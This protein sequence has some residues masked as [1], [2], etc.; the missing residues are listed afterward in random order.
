MFEAYFEPVS[1]QILLEDGVELPSDSLGRR[2]R[3][4]TEGQPFPEL[5]GVRI[6]IIGV[7]DE[8]GLNGEKGQGGGM[9]A[10][11]E[12]LYRLKAH[13]NELVIADFGNLRPGYS[14]E[15]TYAAIASVVSELVP[16]KIIPIFLGGSQDLTY[17][18]Y[19]G[20][21]KN[22]QIINIVS[23]D[24]RFDLGK[25]EDPLSAGS[26]L[27]KIVLEQPNYLFNFSNIGYQTY[28]VGNESVELMKKLFFDTY[29]LGQIRTDITEAEP[30]VRN[31]DVVTVDIS[32]IRQ[33]DAPGTRMA[34]P[35]GFY[36]EEICQIMM[37]TGMSE[38]LS[39]LG[40]YEYVEHLDR[41][42]QT[43]HLIAQMMWYF[44][45][46]VAN[47]KMDLPLTNPANY[48][49]YRVTVPGLTEE[50]TFIKS[51][52]TD[53]WWMKLPLDSSRNR[54]AGHHL[55]PCSYRDYQQACNSEVPDR[56]WNALQKML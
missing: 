25:P 37:Y 29:R 41:D 51:L 49:T 12:K 31:A 28:F 53:R 27:G 52:K 50:V 30:V 3:M 1:P 40:I 24:P 33:A 22:E 23:I 6:A 56:W 42:A 5:E 44:I 34:S 13:Q 16:M 32:C 7:G 45:E 19:W 9:D 36:G 15:D 11:R 10:I 38:K 14:I 54:Y 47:R 35:N 18:Q 26:F 55:L 8:R 4:H 21:K 20:Y 2:M 39:S 46:G 17:G 43:A 48:L